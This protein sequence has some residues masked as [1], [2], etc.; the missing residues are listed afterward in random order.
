MKKIIVCLLGLGPISLFAQNTDVTEFTKKISYKVGER[1]A[2]ED[3]NDEY[4]TLQYQHYIGKNQKESLISMIY[5]SGDNAAD[6][7][8]EVNYFIKDN[9]MFP[10]HVS[11][12]SNVVRYDN[13]SVLNLL[14]EGQDLKKINRTGKINGIDCQY[15]G[16]PAGEYDFTEYSVCYCIDEKNT[17]NNVQSIYNNSSVKGLILSIEDESETYKLVLDKVEDVKFKLNFSGSKFLESF[18]KHQE[19]TKIA[20]QAYAE[21][22]NN[23]E[24][25]YAFDSGV[26]SDPLYSFI[27]S[28]VELEDYN[29]YNFIHPFYSI[30]GNLLYNTK[31]YVAHGTLK[32]DDVVKFY[33]KTYKSVLKNAKS[34]K[35][36]S[37]DEKKLLNDFFKEQL[38]FI[39]DFK[40]DPQ[41]LNQVINDDFAAVEAAAAAT[42]VAVDWYDEYYTKYTSNYNNIEITNSTIAFAYDI[43]DN[44]KLKQNAPQYC[45]DLKNKLPKF[46]N[47]S[48]QTHTYNLA[49]QICDLYLYNNGGNVDYIATIDSMRKSLLEIEKLRSTLSQNDQKLLLQFLKSLD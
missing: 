28:T 30:T 32:R 25:D 29:L 44:E 39:K 1:I 33:E 9:W 11:G 23:E 45:D 46:D 2:G 14:E 36:I 15:Y 49:G 37:S 47:K 24:S 19:E 17:L 7:D 13:Y 10:I 4:K 26:Y 3:I 6:Y 21:A 48:L 42:D 41:D 22:A 27:N 5:K 43:L 34:T 16:I 18:K 38:K 40:V 31:E 12:I 8:S 35:L 20:E